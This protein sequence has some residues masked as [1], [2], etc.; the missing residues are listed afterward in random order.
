MNVFVYINTT[1]NVA[2]VTV[3]L[4]S[5]PSAINL[6]QIGILGTRF[7]CGF[8]ILQTNTNFLPQPKLLTGW[9]VQCKACFGNKP[10]W[11]EKITISPIVM[12]GYGAES[13]PL[14]FFLC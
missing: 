1:N 5:K 14:Y 9:S 3:E 2:A 10:C 12:T 6:T 7:R 4:F 11:G 13:E 8:W